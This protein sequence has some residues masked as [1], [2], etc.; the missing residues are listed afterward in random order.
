M[1]DEAY[2]RER[3]RRYPCAM[4]ELCSV[5]SPM[6]V[7]FV[8]LLC[9]SRCLCLEFSQN[10]EGTECLPEATGLSRQRSPLVPNGL[11]TT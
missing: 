1:C 6:F 10:V 2:R 4:Y 11:G 9:L 3:D 7:K 5:K 8:C